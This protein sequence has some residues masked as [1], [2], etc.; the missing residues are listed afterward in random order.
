[1]DKRPYNRGRVHTIIGALTLSGLE[2]V[3]CGEGWVNK[4]V[5]ETF[6]ES[7]LV[8]MLV[9]GDL[10]FVDGLRAHKS[11]RTRELI[12]A[13]DAELH[14]LP[15]YSPFFNPIEECWSKVKNELRKSAARTNEA[16]QA[17]IAQ[18]IETVTAKDAQAWFKHAGVMTSK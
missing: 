13:A 16:L 17:A 11:K 18:A 7:C 5:F 3:M 6:V 1:M 14:F 10:V 15:P 12:E 9:P 2:A 4:E 8:P